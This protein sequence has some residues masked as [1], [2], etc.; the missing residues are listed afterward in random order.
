MAKKTS[1]FSAT[2]VVEV[3]KENNILSSHEVHHN[4]DIRDLLENLVFDIDDVTI[5]NINVR[6]HG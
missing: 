3:E 6:E 4:E 1:K 5:S 2:F